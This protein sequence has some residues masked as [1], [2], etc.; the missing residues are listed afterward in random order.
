MNSSNGNFLDENGNPVNIVQLLKTGK[1][2]PVENPGPGLHMAA[3]SG[4]FTDENGKPVNIIALI[5]AAIDEDGGD[6]EPAIGGI[7]INGGNVVTPDKNG[8]INLT[9]S[10]DG[11]TVIDSELS[12]S[13]TNPVQNKVVTG[14]IEELSEAVDSLNMLIQESSLGL[15]DKKEGTSINIATEQKE[16]LMSVMLHGTTIQDGTP[17]Y[18]APIDYIGYGDLQTDGTYTVSLSITDNENNEHEIT[19]S[20]LTAPLYKGDYVDFVKGIVVRR[21]VDIQITRFSGFTMTG[22]RGRITASFSPIVTSKMNPLARSNMCTYGRDKDDG[23]LIYS[24]KSTII[25]IYGSSDDDTEE[26]MVEKYKNAKFLLPLSNPISS[27]VVVSDDIKTFFGN[28]RFDSMSG[29][30]VEYR[31]DIKKYIDDRINDIGITMSDG[32]LSIEEGE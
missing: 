28:L 12:A 32:Y 20:G 19:A 25:Y 10:G 13:S 5:D 7:S 1:A 30:T 21:M 6:D 2:V 18:D 8:I 15:I 26:R 16:S 24:S 3:H 11:S 27:P 22:G 4:W 31:A 9:I 23:F 14:E 17:A 29:V